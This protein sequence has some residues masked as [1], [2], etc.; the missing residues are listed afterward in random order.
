MFPEEEEKTDP[1]L[2]FPLEGTTRE[3]KAPPPQP[4]EATA[5]HRSASSTV[6]K[7]VSMASDHYQLDADPAS[8]V[9]KK[10]VARAANPPLPAEKDISVGALLGLSTLVFVLCAGVAFAAVWAIY[11]V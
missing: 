4:V 9:S 5:S 11:S 7:T 3:Q 1:S 8:H 6:P 10:P 2:S